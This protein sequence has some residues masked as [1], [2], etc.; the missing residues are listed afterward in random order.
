MR[1]QINKNFNQKEWRLAMNCNIVKRETVGLHFKNQNQKQKKTETN[2]TALAMQ[3]KTE[4]FL[5]IK[6][7]NSVLQRTRKKKTLNLPLTRKMQIKTT[8]Y[9]SGK[10]K[11]TSEEQS[12]VLEMKNEQ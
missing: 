3:E 12:K 10:I 2:K 7:I 5:Y 9:T 6:V 8:W 1:T 11:M 4:K